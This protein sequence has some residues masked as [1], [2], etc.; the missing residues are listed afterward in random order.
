MR[1]RTTTFNSFRGISGCVVFLTLLATSCSSKDLEKVFDCLGESARVGI[2][3]ENE[4]GDRTVNFSI[5]YFGDLN[6]GT[7]AWVFGDGNTGTGASTSH[8]YA[9]AG[10]YSVRA[11]VNLSDGTENCKPEQ[12]RSVTVE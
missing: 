6:V 2:E 7:V 10:T 4:N 8:T 9:E 11:I 3:V 5:D 12:T 1:T